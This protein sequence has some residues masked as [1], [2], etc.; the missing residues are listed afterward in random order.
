M[1]Q[2]QVTRNSQ[3]A[4]LAQITFIG[5]FITA[6]VTAQ[7]VSS[8]LMAVTLPVIGLVAMPG[9]TLAYAATFFATDCMSELYG[10]EYAR[11]VVNTGF[12]MNF[13]LF[14]LVWL[15]VQA[16]PAQGSIDQ[17]MFSTVMLSSG[18]IILGSLSAY[19]I[20]QNF[21]VTAFHWYRS[22]TGESYLWLRNIGSTGISQ[23]IDTAIFTLVAF[24]VAPQILGIGHALPWA[25]I[26]SIIVGQY[27]GKLLIAIGDT[28]LVYGAVHLI[29]NRRKAGVTR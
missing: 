28:P 17:E 1:S 24:W 25:V 19:L 22:K 9:G 14:A 29:R 23:L 8:K 18:N 5:L 6:L 27:V 13:V 10:K 12:V 16:E 4:S 21:D 11:K 15:T 7:L 26:T 20:S 3:F 2:A